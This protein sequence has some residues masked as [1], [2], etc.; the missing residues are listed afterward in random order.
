MAMVGMVFVCVFGGA[1]LGIALRWFVPERHL[2]AESR[3][4]VMLGVGLLTTMA[5]LVLGLLIASA[6]NSHDIRNSELAQLAAGVVLLDRALAHYGPETRDA[7]DVLRRSILRVIEQTWPSKGAARPPELN[8]RAARTEDLY[9]MI[10]ALSPKS[11]DQRF[12]RTE[13]LKMGA[14]LGRTRWLLFAQGGSS[15][16]APFLAILV[17]WVTVIFFSFGLF[18]PSNSVVVATLLI[19]ALSV[20]AAIFLILELDESFQGLIQVSSAPLRMAV[21]NLGQ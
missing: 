18:A 3:T 6:K 13:A 20:S 15:I 10:Q 12:L 1:L 4:S 11:D 2:S 16:P 14:E 19:C 8:P 7:R 5:A 21:E 9:D 17:F